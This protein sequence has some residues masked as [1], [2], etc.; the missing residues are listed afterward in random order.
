[1]DPGVWCPG[2]TTLKVGAQQ[3][4]TSRLAVLPAHSWAWVAVPPPSLARPAHQQRRTPTS[5]Q[6]PRADVCPDSAAGEGGQAGMRAAA[7]RSDGRSNWRIMARASRTPRKHSS[8]I[9]A[10]PAAFWD[11][12]RL[13]SCP[14]AAAAA[15]A[16]GGSNAPLSAHGPAA[17][18]QTASPIPPP[19]G[20]SHCAGLRGRA[21]RQSW[22]SEALRRR[23]GHMPLRAARLKISYPHRPCSSVRRPG[24]WPSAAKESN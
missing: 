10:P 20:C 24:E 21:A 15:T 11:S 12:L 6:P 5:G 13:P 4:A 19:S 23:G 7:Q 2:T 22:W 16:L 17:H 14:C 8:T 1:M 3:A 9:I 18:P